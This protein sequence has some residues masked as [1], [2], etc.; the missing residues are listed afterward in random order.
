[1]ESIR[2]NTSII[3]D[4]KYTHSRPVSEMEL[5]MGIHFVKFRVLTQ[6]EKFIE[7]KW[8]KLAFL[9][10]FTELFHKVLDSHISTNCISLSSVD[11]LCSFHADDLNSRAQKLKA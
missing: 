3:S 5:V 8:P 9:R 6:I 10:S 11:L 2:R 1:M 4:Y 7:C